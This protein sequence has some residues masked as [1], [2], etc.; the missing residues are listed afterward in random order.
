MG[1]PFYALSGAGSKLAEAIQ[2][3]DWIILYRAARDAG[4]VGIFEATN[5][6]INGSVRLQ[7]QIRPFAVKIPWRALALCESSP[8]RMTPLIERLEFITNKSNF[9]M[10]LRT[11]LRSLSNSD[12]CLIAGAIREN[13]TAI[14]AVAAKLPTRIND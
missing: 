2:I 6:A 5:T 8:V 10:S 4:F 12:F 3:G 9:G 11:N 7:G 13:S 1:H 14:D